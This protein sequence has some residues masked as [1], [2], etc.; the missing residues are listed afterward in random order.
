MA[1]A[2]ACAKRRLLDCAPLAVQAVEL[3]GDARGFAR[4]LLQQQPH[5]EIGAADAAAGIDA[6]AE[7]E[8][9]VPGLGRTG[10]PRHIHQRGQAEMLAPPQRDQAFGD[11]SAVEALERHHVG[12]RAE[13]DQMQQPTAD[14]APAAHRSR[15]CACA[16][17]RLTA[18][19]VTKTSPTAARWPSRERSSTRLGLTTATRRRQFLVGLVMVDHDAVEAELLRFRQRLDAGGA[20]IDGDQ[21][22]HAAS[23][24]SRG[25]PRRSAR[26]LRRCGREYA[27]SDRGRIAAR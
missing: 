16:R 18:T 27:R 3:G 6:R 7:Q 12:D 11:E 10:Q 22:R 20:A 21:Q 1:S 2:S 8:S 4:V 25:W 9:E 23:R 17:S 14:R 13:R 24:Q 5:A 15:N 26:S 19:S